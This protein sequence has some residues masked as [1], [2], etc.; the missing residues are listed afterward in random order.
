MEKRKIPPRHELSH[1]PMTAALLVNDKHDLISSRK[2]RAENADGTSDTRLHAERL[3]HMQ[4]AML[5]LHSGKADGK[6]HRYTVSVSRSLL[7][8][9][10]LLLLLSVCPQLTLHFQRGSPASWVQGT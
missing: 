10:L 9:L 3:V 7:L 6:S 4:R 1:M 8:L 5:E 2:K